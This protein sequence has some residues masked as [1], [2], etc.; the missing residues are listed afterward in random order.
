MQQGQI[1]PV[2]VVRPVLALVLSSASIPSLYNPSRSLR[3][4][5]LGILNA[6][7]SSACLAGRS[8]DI[9]GFVSF[10]VVSLS[11]LSENAGRGGGADFLFC[12]G[13]HYDV[14][15][16]RGL[17]AS[18]VLPGHRPP[19][20]SLLP[21]DSSSLSSPSFPRR[22][23]VSPSASSWMTQWRSRRSLRAPCQAGNTAGD[24]TRRVYRRAVSTQ[25]RIEFYSGSVYIRYEEGKK[26]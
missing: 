25:R 11:A 5:P 8:G 24:R 2:P 21:C 16:D 15:T 23:P 6:L 14:V 26:E 1:S 20:V 4:I 19:A 18:R 10:T 12:V 22:C 9:R 13:V 7:S 17:S 3:K